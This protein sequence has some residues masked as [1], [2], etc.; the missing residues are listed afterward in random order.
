MPI[1]NLNEAVFSWDVLDSVEPTRL[2]AFKISNDK[3][4]MFYLD[5][6]DMKRAKTLAKNYYANVLIIMQMYLKS[7]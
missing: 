1:F 7:I 6:E 5:A 3:S 4:L 2:R